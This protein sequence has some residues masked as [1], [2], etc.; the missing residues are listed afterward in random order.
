[1]I[2]VNSI[3]VPCD[4]QRLCADWAGGE[5]CMLRA[6]SSAGGLTLGSIR[7]KNCDTDEKWYYHIWMEFAS[8]IGDAAHI[9][10]NNEH[11]DSDKLDCA[12]E[13][14]DNICKLLAESYGLEDWDSYED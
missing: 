14:I 11:E 4:I 3:K 8:D 2:P 9:A 13:W 12:D 10:H 7:P 6:V 5:D 1:M